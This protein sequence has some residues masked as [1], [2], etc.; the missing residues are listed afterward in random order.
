[1][2]GR[3]FDD[4]DKHLAKESCLQIHESTA[5]KYLL[6]LGYMGQEKSQYGQGLATSLL[7]NQSH[8]FGKPAHLDLAQLNIARGCR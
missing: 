6:H 8:H 1:M 7:L 5:P 4:P 3:Y 2:L